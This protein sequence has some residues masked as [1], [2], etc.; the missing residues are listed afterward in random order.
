MTLIHKP[1]VGTEKHNRGLLL[2]WICKFCNG[3]ND[4]LREYCIYC[5]VYTSF[6]DS[7]LD[8]VA[9]ATQERRL[10]L[11]TMSEKPNTERGEALFSELFNHEQSQVANMTF[12]QLNEHINELENIAFEAR[13]RLRSASKNQ[14]ERILN[15]SQEERDKLISKNYP[16]DSSE[17]SNLNLPKREKTTKA[18]KMQNEL[19]ALGLPQEQVDDMLRNIRIKEDLKDRK[20]N[21]HKYLTNGTRAIP[22]QEE[23]KARPSSTTFSRSTQN[24]LFKEFLSIN[25]KPELVKQALVNVEV[26]QSSGL[27]E[28]SLDV[29]KTSVNEAKAKLT[30]TYNTMMLL[31][32]KASKEA[33]LSLLEY[34]DT[35]LDDKSKI[36]FN[37]VYVEPKQDEI[38]EVEESKPEAPNWLPKF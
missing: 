23:L 19:L 27:D 3:Y 6:R 33:G 34:L 38:V 16:F 20:D 8:L 18:D 28:V 15:L 31:G 24:S 17:R 10:G 9:Y 37:L 7:E 14:K 5:Q 36:W 35:V 30:E 2:G 32:P 29:I 26:L 22:E 4:L 13:T 21:P 25:L 12:E 11:N 1:I